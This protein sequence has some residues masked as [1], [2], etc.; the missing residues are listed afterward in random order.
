MVGRITKEGV[1]LW[2]A[3]VLIAILAAFVVLEWIL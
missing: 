2:L 1:E 3:I